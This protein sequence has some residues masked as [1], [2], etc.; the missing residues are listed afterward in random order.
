MTPELT[1]TG[2]LKRGSRGRDVRRAQEWLCLHAIQVAVDGDFG[3]ATEFAVSEFQRT[4]GL[5]PTGV[6]DEDTFDELVLPMRRALKPVAGGGL[7]AHAVAYANQ[8]LKEHPREVGG[9]N[10][11]PWVRLYMKGNQGQEW[12]WCAGFASFVLKQA[13]DSLGVALPLRTSFSCDLLAANAKGEGLFVREAQIP[14]VPIPPG[15]LFLQR[16]TSSDWVHTGIVVNTREGVFETIEGNTNDEGSREGF[17][18]C[19][20]FRGYKQK[21]FIVIR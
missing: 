14:D 3:P 13:C 16:R 5:A 9:Q 6:V 17:E 2:Q 11:G 8:H 20:R 1:L 19:R 12:A 15:S 7:G 4:A 18:V 10:M 21:D